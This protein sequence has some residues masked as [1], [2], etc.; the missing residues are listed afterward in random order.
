MNR[1]LFPDRTLVG[2]FEYC[3]RTYRI[4]S[5]HSITGCDH[6]KAKSVNFLSCAEEMDAFEPDIFTIDANEPRV[7]HYDVAKMTFHKNGKDCEVLF[8]LLTEQGLT[9]SYAIHYDKREF[10]EGKPLVVSHIVKSAKKEYRYDFLFINEKK[11]KVNS[12][13]YIFDDSI[14]ECKADH[15]MIVVDA[16]AI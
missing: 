7:D 16:E 4:A 6:R 3:G 5:L 15:A 10:E 1:T 14:K 8:N 2:E 13:D 11:F 12:V 9:D